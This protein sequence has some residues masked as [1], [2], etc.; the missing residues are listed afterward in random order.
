MLARLQRRFGHREVQL[1]RR[2]YVDGAD[3]GIGKQVFV[4][5]GGSLDAQVV[6]ELSRCLS[7]PSGNT[8]DFYI[9]E[10]AQRFRMDAAH[11]TNSK[12]C[13]F[14]L[15]HIPPILSG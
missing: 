14:Q 11:K 15:F 3:V 6:G 9:A 2:T 10:T 8:D 7:S 12:D 5:A 4:I 13:N 1:V